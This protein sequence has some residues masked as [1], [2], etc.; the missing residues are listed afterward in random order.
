MRKTNQNLS[1]ILTVGECELWEKI[2]NEDYSWLK[3][4]DDKKKTRLF[5]LID[6]NSNLQKSC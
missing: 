3:I 5:K 2:G 6:I 4:K 1:R